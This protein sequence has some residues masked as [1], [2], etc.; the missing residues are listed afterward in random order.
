[1]FAAHTS[2]IPSGTVSVERRSASFISGSS[3]ATVTACTATAQTNPRSR[4]SIIASIA[5]IACA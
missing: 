1:M 5:S 3:C 4:R 2:G